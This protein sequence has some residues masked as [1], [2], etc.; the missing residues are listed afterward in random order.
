MRPQ[1]K[2]SR[3]Q[4]APRLSIQSQQDP[5]RLSHYPSLND[6]QPTVRPALHHQPTELKSNSYHEPTLPHHE[7]YQSLPSVIAAELSFSSST[8]NNN[9]V[10]PTVRNIPAL[11]KNLS[12]GALHHK[13]PLKFNKGSFVNATTFSAPISPKYLDKLPP[14]HKTK[15]TMKR[16]VGPHTRHPPLSSNGTNSSMSPRP[17]GINPYHDALLVNNRCNKICEDQE[18]DDCL[19]SLGPVHSKNVRN[20]SKPLRSRRKMTNP[21]HSKARKS[22]QKQGFKRI[23]SMPSLNLD[24]SR[25]SIEE[26]STKLHTHHGAHGQVNNLKLTFPD[27]LC[28]VPKSARPSMSSIN[29]EGIK[30]NI[31]LQFDLAPK[32]IDHRSS[33]DITADGAFHQNGFTVCSTGMTIDGDSESPRKKRYDVKPS[34]FVEVSILGRGSS[35]VVYKSWDL[36]HQRFIALKCISAFEQDKRRQIMNELGLLTNNNCP[37]IVP[38]YGSYFDSGQIIF[39]LEYFDIGSLQVPIYCA[40]A[41]AEC[42]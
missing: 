23:Q 28:A 7:S 37:E 14:I 5:P 12:L 29:A 40:R 4:S 9:S 15:N 24:L 1:K 22:N 32:S 26:H 33:Y 38:F 17:F 31:A 25:L 34:D 13:Y 6:L 2:K 30:S 27:D 36:K 41:V 21:L 20:K 35:S 39:C 3:R 10:S 42:S 18:T 19:H 8:S 11:R 16:H